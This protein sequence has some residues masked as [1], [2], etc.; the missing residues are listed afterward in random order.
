MS[1]TPEMEKELANAAK[2]Y[3]SLHQDSCEV[4]HRFYIGQACDC[5]MQYLIEDFAK[6]FQAEKEKALNSLAS[7]IKSERIQQL[8]NM[9]HENQIQFALKHDPILNRIDVCLAKALQDRNE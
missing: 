7:D 9:L 2:Q 4:N 8:K 1:N 6:I 5:S 3:K